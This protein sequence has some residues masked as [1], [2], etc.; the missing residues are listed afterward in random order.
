MHFDIYV[1][2]FQYIFTTIVSNRTE[3]DNI[4]EKMNKLSDEKQN[5]NC[6][7]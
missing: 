6:S 7:Y 4:D 3:K 2:L 1:T 5:M